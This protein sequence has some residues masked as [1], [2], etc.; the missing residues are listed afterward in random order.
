MFVKNMIMKKFLMFM[1]IMIA[2][3]SLSSCN[4][5]ENKTKNKAE[6]SLENSA[7]NSLENKAKKQ[8]HTTIK[9]VARNPKTYKITNEKVIFSND[10]MCTISFIGRGQNGFGGYSSSKMEYTVTKLRKSDLHKDG[11]TTYCETLLN[12][13]NE[14]ERDCSIKK[15]I[16]NIDNGLLNVSSKKLYNK[17]IKKGMSKED[18]KSNYLYR[19]AIINLTFGEGREI[20]GNGWCPSPLYQLSVS[21][22]LSY[23]QT[24]F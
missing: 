14:F 7:K 9:E 8:L 21:E 10:S 13:E 6:N 22:D 3:V 17:F 20:G 12:M 5:F 4:S 18:A 11:R 1:A 24:H 19:I 23:P 16:Y 15:E 2:V